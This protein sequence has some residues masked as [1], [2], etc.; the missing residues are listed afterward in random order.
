MLNMQTES[1]KNKSPE[2]IMELVT[3]AAAIAALE[4]QPG[5]VQDAKIKAIEDTF[6]RVSMYRRNGIMGKLVH[7]IFVKRMQ[8]I[9][10]VGTVSELKEIQNEP[11]PRY[12]GA[13]FTTG[14]AC[15][16]EEELIVWSMASLRA[17]LNEAGMKRYMEL[18]R[19]V[20]GFLPGEDK[21]ED[22]EVSK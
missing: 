4:E 18:F 14:D 2:E 19:Q 3:A 15:V 5:P 13:G 6:R 12:T 17:P 7:T 9:E 22:Q 21:A 16:P 11:K 20:F 1:M 8:L 10:K